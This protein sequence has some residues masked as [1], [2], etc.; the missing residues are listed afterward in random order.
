MLPEFADAFVSQAIF[1]RV[2][3]LAWDEVLNYKPPADKLV[4]S[5]AVRHY[6]RA[7]ALRA[8][9]DRAGAAREQAAFEGDRA[10]IPG[11]RPWG[12]SKTGDIL[13]IASETLSA[14]MAPD[15]EEELKHWR[16]AVEVQDK[17]IYD[18][19]P[20]W[21]YLTR[22][23]LGAALVRAGRAPEGEQVFREAL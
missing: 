19:P 22:E 8:R 12:Q 11:D 17:L 4:M 18:E 3:T 9:N 16:K 21:Y 6:A 1:A 20:D 5:S 2:Y 15:S 23:S 14:R 10:K 7:L 13:T